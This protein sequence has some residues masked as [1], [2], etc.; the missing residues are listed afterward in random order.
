MEVRKKPF[1]DNKKITKSNQDPYPWLDQEDPCRFHT[2]DEL[3]ESKIDLSKS[4][5][6]PEE[7]TEVVEMLKQKRE[8]FSLRDEI[9]TCPYFEVKLQLRGD[10]PFFVQPYPIREEQKSYSAKRNG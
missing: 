2:D 8:A 6:T 9:G 10:T 7:K 1:K 4:I 3:I 5:L